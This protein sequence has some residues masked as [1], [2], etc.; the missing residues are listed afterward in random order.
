MKRQ[1]DLDRVWRAV[2][3]HVSANGAQH[4]EYFG[5]FSRS[6]DASAAV[7]RSKRHGWFDSTTTGIVQSAAVTWETRDE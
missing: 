3:T 2:V 5:P 6:N 1:T 7:T 4:I